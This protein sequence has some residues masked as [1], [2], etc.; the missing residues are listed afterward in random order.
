MTDDRSAK[1][2]SRRSEQGKKKIVSFGAVLW[3]I[4]RGVPYIGG[5][6]FNL[7]AHLAKCGMHS[8][9]LTSI[10]RDELGE[11]ALREIDRLGVDRTYVLVD[12]EH[13]TPTVRVHLTGD[14]QPTYDVEENVSYDFIRLS[15]QQ[16]DAFHR[17]QL[18]AFCFGTIEQRSE[19]TRTTLH[20]ILPRLKDVHVLYDVNIRLHYYS[21]QIIIDSL[22]H[23][24]IAKLND[25][26]A[27][28]MA[29]LLYG[30]RMPQKDFASALRDDY[31]LDT[32]LVTRGHNGC[33][34]L[35][36]ED[37]TEHPGR[38]VRVADAVGAGDA[39]AAAFLA[40]Y[41]REKSPAEAAAV[42]NE[43]GAYVASQNGA[44][45]DYSDEIRTLLN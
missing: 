35:D 12:E 44:V 3:D 39:F 40:E 23:A 42:A 2:D 45:P 43:L 31:Q 16:M 38:K 1:M 25:E 29:D 24:T 15:Q 30:R 20:R 5:A 18:S 13:P 14:G 19:V 17:E 22:A 9:M 32:V 6:P 28:L 33:A 4:I 8:G 26:E 10:G 21:K 34:V 37:W 36:G 11:R 7:A 41:C 27:R